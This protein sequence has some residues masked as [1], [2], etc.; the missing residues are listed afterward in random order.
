MREDGEA[1]P[2]RH[3]L[4]R[5]QAAA[6]VYHDLKENQRATFAVAAEYGRWL[7][8]SLVLI[9][10]GAMWGLLSYLGSIGLKAENLSQFAA[11]IWSLMAGIVLAMCSGLAAWVNWSMHSHN[12]QC[13]ARHD[14][15]WDPERWAD[16][17][18][19][20]I[21]LDITNW[22]SIGCGVGSLIAAVMAG[23]FMLQ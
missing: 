22:L 2:K 11:P 15:L 21:G 9:N 19:H 4:T 10:G 18:P 1:P 12:Y 14:M 23:A 3:M 16:D 6:V 17:P 13:M 7:I 8:A 20:D 5:E